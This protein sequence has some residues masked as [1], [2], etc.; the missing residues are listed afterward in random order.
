MEATSLAI[1]FLGMMGLTVVVWCFMYFQRIGYMIKN[2]IPAHAGSTPDKMHKLLPDSINLPANNLSNLFE[3]PVLFYAI[4][5]YLLWADQVDAMH[6]A[7]AWTYF[8]LRSVHS[9]VQCTINHVMT[10]FL[11]YF[12]S[13]IVLFTMIIRTLLALFQ[14][15]S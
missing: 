2:K 5:L 3:L 1:P 10:R 8:L 9:L 14:G 13:C 12:V 11:L 15:A 4:C 6:V 7:C